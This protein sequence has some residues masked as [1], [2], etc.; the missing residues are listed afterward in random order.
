MAR[1]DSVSIEFRSTKFTYLRE[2]E[3]QPIEKNYFSC[4][5][6]S[7]CKENDVSFHWLIN[8][9]SVQIAKAVRTDDNHF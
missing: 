6:F 3:M 8:Y 1:Q 5:L 4:F 9:K 2:E 7:T